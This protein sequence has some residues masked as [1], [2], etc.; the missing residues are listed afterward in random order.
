[1]KEAFKSKMTAD[2]GKY[3]KDSIALI[4]VKKLSLYVLPV[5]S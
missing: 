2:V 3:F 4:L 1:M 5:K